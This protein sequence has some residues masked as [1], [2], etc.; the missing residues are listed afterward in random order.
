MPGSSSGRSSIGANIAEGY[1]RHSGREYERF[2]EIAFGSANE[3]DNWLTVLHDSGLLAAE[4]AHELQARN[5]EV[6]R[7][8]ATML[9]TLRE[10]RQTPGANL[11][12]ADELYDSRVEG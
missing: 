2:L 1:G 7:I 8:L 9:R 11:K 5:E 12:E 4:V 10:K 3:A 6:L